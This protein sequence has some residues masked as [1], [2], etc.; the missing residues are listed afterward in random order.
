[1]QK[2]DWMG[3]LKLIY[4]KMFFPESSGNFGASRGLDNGALGLP[5]ENLDDFTKI[6]VQRAEKGVDW[7]PQK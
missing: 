3:Y 5:K 7:W 6:A 2:G 4:S 1:M